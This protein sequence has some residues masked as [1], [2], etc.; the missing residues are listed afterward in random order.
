MSQ[1]PWLGDALR[2]LDGLAADAE[3]TEGVLRL[4][5]LTVH[6]TQAA[7]AALAPAPARG[8]FTA[9][10]QDF[11]DEPGPETVAA[12]A[13]SRPDTPPPGDAG[14]RLPS[15]FDIRPAAASA[16]PPVW[17]SSVAP[18]VLPST[19]PRHAPLPALLPRQRRRAVLTTA[20]AVRVA[21]GPPDMRRIV[22]EL[23]RC[24]PLRSVPRRLCRTLRYGVDLRIDRAP[25]LRPFHDDQ[26]Q[27][28]EALLQLMPRERV[29]TTLV[30]GSC[31]T[32]VSAT[33]RWRAPR[34]LGPS[35]RPA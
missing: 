6:A 15:R 2:A 10:P 8:D 28:R 7:V 20:L 19:A 18:L 23:G 11:I 9:W 17:L 14:R 1:E 24:R 3:A 13:A 27:L 22:A 33:A 34:H 12:S 5:G 4:L 29:L 16:P 25:W 31:P 26:M 30:D 21:E 35:G 32:W